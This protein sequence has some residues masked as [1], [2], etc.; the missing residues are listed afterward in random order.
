[1]SFYRC[2]LKPVVVYEPAT[3]K[4]RSPGQKNMIIFKMLKLLIANGDKLF[5][6]FVTNQNTPVLEK[7]KKSSKADNCLL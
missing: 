4:S 3:P 5:A 6:E 2:H 7:S 1:M